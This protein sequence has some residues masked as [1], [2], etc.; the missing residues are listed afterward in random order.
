MQSQR[1]CYTHE[2][3]GWWYEGEARSLG[4]ASF[5]SLFSCFFPSWLQKK[6][7]VIGN[8]I[9]QTVSFP[10]AAISHLYQERIM[11]LMCNLH[12]L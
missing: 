10:F 12:N 4:A 8:W 9:S 2:F 6:T 1:G 7:N 11:T 5:P 3:L